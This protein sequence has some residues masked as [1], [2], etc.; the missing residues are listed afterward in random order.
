VARCGMGGPPAARV[1]AASA[2]FFWVCV[3]ARSRLFFAMETDR[4][5]CEGGRVFAPFRVPAACASS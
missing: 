4:T 3:F 1:E 5:S 2:A